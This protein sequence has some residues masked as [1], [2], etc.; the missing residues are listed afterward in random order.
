MYSLLIVYLMAPFFFIILLFG[1]RSLRSCSLVIFTSCAL[2]LLSD[3]ALDLSLSPIEIEQSFIYYCNVAILWDS[4]CA[5]LLIT[6]KLFNQESGKQALLLCFAVLCH[7]MVAYGLN[8]FFRSWYVEL[9]L[10]IGLLQMLVAYHGFRAASIELWK[11]GRW[12]FDDNRCD[13][14]CILERKKAEE[15]L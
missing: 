11:F 12:M 2:N 5:L 10:I 14:S 8:S 3:N 9:I 7:I 1:E 6:S 15:G 13:P 4:A